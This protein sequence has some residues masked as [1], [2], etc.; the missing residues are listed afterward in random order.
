MTEQDTMEIRRA[1]TTPRRALLAG[2][3]GG[4]AAL[5]AE[6]LLRTT[7]ALAADGDPLLLGDENNTAGSPTVLKGDVTNPQGGAVLLEINNLSKDQGASGMA[8]SGASIGI[9]G[10]GKGWDTTLVHEGGTGVYARA[11]SPGGTGMEAWAGGDRGIGVRAFGAHEGIRAQAGPGGTAIVGVGGAIAIEGTA[12][13]GGSGGIGVAAQ[14][15]QGAIALRVTGPAVFSSSGVATIAKGQ[16]SVTVTPGFDI[17]TTSKV[18][19]TLQSWGGTL[20]TVIKNETANTFT[21]WM[22]ANATQAT[23]AAWFVIN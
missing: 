18:F 19:V 16:K 6:S 2:A 15:D 9:I 12:G 21:I 7:P 10:D 1:P 14:G 8:V 17:G 3:A 5:A 22:A 11:G 23:S 4:I 13:S 20:K